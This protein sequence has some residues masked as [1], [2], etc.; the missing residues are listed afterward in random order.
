MNRMTRLTAAAAGL[1]VFAGLTLTG[2]A[3]PARGGV[4]AIPSSAPAADR[5]TTV[6]D[7]VPAPKATATLIDG[8]RVELASLW[9]GR[10][11]VVQFT[12]TWCTQCTT[13]EAD[14]RALSETYGDDLL[15]VHVALDEPN[16][17][18]QKYLDDNEVTGPVIVDRTG[19]IW[20]DY[21]VKEPPMTALIDTSGGIVRMWPGGASGDQLRTALENVITG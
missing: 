18:I 1:A 5:F 16:A 3:S 6:A 13:A 4:E 20:R 14:L 7:A 12:S 19:S 8:T 2:C 21:A 9:K 10:P 17:T 11:L 15:V